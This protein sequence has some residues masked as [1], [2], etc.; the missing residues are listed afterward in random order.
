MVSREAAGGGGAGHLQHQLH[1]RGLLPL[2][3]RRHHHGRG[4]AVQREEV[5]AGST[6][7][8]TN[9]TLHTRY[10]SMGQVCCTHP[11]SSTVTP[12]STSTPPPYTAGDC[13]V[14]SP[15]LV[16]TSGVNIKITTPG[17]VTTSFGEFPWMAAIMGSVLSSMILRLV[18]IL[19]RLQLRRVP[20]WWQSAE[21]AGGAHGCPLRVQPSP[22]LP[23][24]GHAN[25]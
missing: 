23:Q 18:P 3:H 19:Q 5:R 10:C 22:G 14:P 9:I 17:A 6:F 11:Q 13:G 24:G 25:C 1:L 21:Q 7:S 8:M 12:T 15:D 20:V 4:G 16:R 2:P